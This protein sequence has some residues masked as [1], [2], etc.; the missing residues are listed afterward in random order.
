MQYK[1][2]NSS[3]GR[4]LHPSFPLYLFIYSSF[5]D[6]FTVTQIINYYNVGW[7]G[8]KWM[9]K[10]KGCVRK[11]SWPNFK[12][13]YYPGIPLE[14]LRKITKN[15][16]QDGR[17]SGRDLNPAAPEYK[18]GMLKTRPWPSILLYP[19]S[20]YSTQHPGL[21]HCH[22]ITPIIFQQ[23]C[24]HMILSVERTE[25]NSVVGLITAYISCNTERSL[26]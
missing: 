1:L 6:V 13:G 20:K 24:R 21:E 3:L 18:A 7:E 12:V 8:D 23:V 16:S 19:R 22:R 9:M 4:F 11:R 17:C 26:V 25:R 14:V 5:T 2:S 15:L 10:W